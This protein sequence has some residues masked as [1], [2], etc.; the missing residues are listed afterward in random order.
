MAAQESI[1]NNEA[2]F[3]CGHTGCVLTVVNLHDRYTESQETEA[4]S[5]SLRLPIASS[6][7]GPLESVH[8]HINGNT[9]IVLLKTDL[10]PVLFL[11][12]SV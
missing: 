2:V 5:C 6:V 10:W 1:A 3:Q 12:W 9:A 4:H 11:T 8:N 7:V